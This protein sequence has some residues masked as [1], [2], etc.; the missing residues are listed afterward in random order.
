M[1]GL[2][3]VMWEDGE[4][5]PFEQ[6]LKELGRMKG[7]G[8]RRDAASVAAALERWQE[9]GFRRSSTFD[10]R[11]IEGRPFEPKLWE[12]RLHRSARSDGVHGYRIFFV[13]TRRPSTNQ[14]VVV[15]L[16]LWAKK[17]RETPPR[18]LVE[19][20]RRAERALEAIAN[21][22]FFGPP[23]GTGHH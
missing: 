21:R 3:L 6:E 15:L 7:P 19:A 10:F 16:M 4:V 18:I 12:A 1:T 9:V 23:D 11:P 14:Q 20:W 5:I 13:Q 22:T 17:G 8:C 2:E